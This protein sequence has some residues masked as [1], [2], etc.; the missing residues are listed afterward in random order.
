MGNIQERNVNNNGSNE[1]QNRE[2]F[3]P[4]KVDYKLSKE[5]KDYFA[6]MAQFNRQKFEENMENDDNFSFALERKSFSKSNNFMNKK[7][8]AEYIHWKDFLTECLETLEENKVSWAP[9]L[10]EKLEEM[11]DIYENKYQSLL[12]YKDFYIRTIPESLE[13]EQD[14]GKEGE[15]KQIIRKK[16]RKPKLNKEIVRHS[17]TYNKSK[18]QNEGYNAPNIRN[19]NTSEKDRYTEMDVTDDLGGSFRS[20]NTDE[21][22]EDDPTIEFRKN[23][24]KSKRYVRIFSEHIQSEDHPIAFVIRNFGAVFTEYIYEELKKIRKM[25]EEGTE[26]IVDKIREIK[27]RVTKELQKFILNLENVLKLFYCQVIDFEC[28]S[29]EKDDIINLL[30]CQVFKSGRIYEGLKEL[31]EYDL[32]DVIIKLKEKFAELV[33]KTPY[34]LG[35]HEKFC[36]NKETVELQKKLKRDKE[37]KNKAA[38]GKGEEKKEEE[39]K[40]ESPEKKSLQVISQGIIE[41]KEDEEED[42]KKSKSS[43]SS[44]KDSQGLIDENKFKTNFEISMDDRQS[45]PLN[46]SNPQEVMFLMYGRESNQGNVNNNL[47]IQNQNASRYTVNSFNKKEFNFPVLHAAIRQSVNITNYD[48]T[49]CIESGDIPPPYSSAITMLASIKK[50]RTPFEKMLIIASISDE[51]TSC[52]DEFWKDMTDYIK[53]TYLSIEA[54]ELMTIVLYIIIKSNM[55]ELAVYAEM[56]KNFTT[57][58]TRGT[59]LGYY[60]ANLS[61]SLC[62][63]EELEDAKNL[64][65]RDEQ[66]KNAKNRL[67]VI[68]LDRMTTCK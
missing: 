54:D 39:K 56:I 59:T 2:K 34:H 55:S 12:F 67:S 52:V 60:Y 44:G 4:K 14:K 46:S 28:L 31:Y 11:E 23:R 53:P 58:T 62:Y 64:I 48:I 33:D 43:S 61:A 40:M 15:E 10:N 49:K 37:E 20:I 47:L 18:G 8:E 25:K 51:I 21:L 6:L 63:I 9:K 38:E 66:L 17:I 24:L 41:E 32:E 45:N 30:T 16:E 42:D 36:L 13:E 27:E 26:G 22:A 57:E 19:S 35:I 3:Y 50:Y 7:K 5:A 29:E 68:N 1:G 65:K